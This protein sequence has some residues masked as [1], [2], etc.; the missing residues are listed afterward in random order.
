MQFPSN[1]HTAIFPV[2]NF[3]VFIEARQRRWVLNRPRT[4]LCI[5]TLV[6]QFTIYRPKRFSR[7]PRDARYACFGESFPIESEIYSG[8]LNEKN[9]W[10]NSPIR[11]S[12]N[13]IRRATSLLIGFHGLMAWVHLCNFPAILKEIVPHVSHDCTKI[14]RTYHVKGHSCHS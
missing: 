11:G 7:L 8:T 13:R 9:V 2:S 4:P 14:S 5:C 6:I 12:M 3:D 10:F 1:L